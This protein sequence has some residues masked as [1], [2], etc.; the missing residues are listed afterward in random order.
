MKRK[1]EQVNVSTRQVRFESQVEFP[2]LSSSKKAVSPC[3]SGPKKSL[4]IVKGIVVPIAPCI[5]GDWLSGRLANKADEPQTIRFELPKKTVFSNKSVEKLNWEERNALLQEVFN[6]GAYGMK[7]S[8]NSNWDEETEDEDWY[9]IA[10][11]DELD[12]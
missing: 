6:C 11:E 8:F 9:S 12:E 10:E 4:V 5:D 3:W 2:A 7:K 1:R